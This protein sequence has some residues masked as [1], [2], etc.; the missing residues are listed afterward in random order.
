VYTND[1]VFPDIIPAAKKIAH[2]I[3][4]QYMAENTQH[5]KHVEK[6]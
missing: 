4:Q 5:M 2:W 6:V 1:V 3:L